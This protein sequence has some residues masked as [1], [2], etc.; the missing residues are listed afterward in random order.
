VSVS[1]GR[2]MAIKSATC[3]VT[4]LLVCRPLAGWGFVSKVQ[5][6]KPRRLLPTEAA[7]AVAATTAAATDDVIKDVGDQALS[8]VQ[9]IG[10]LVSRSANNA[11]GRDFTSEKDNAN[12]DGTG[13]SV[14]SNLASTID[15]D[16]N[17]ER[18]VWAALANLEKDSKLATGRALTVD[19]NVS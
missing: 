15:A 9:W 5:T 14:Y 6:Q 10:S 11:D 4:L 1:F 12:I 18:Q 19:G 16:E 7:T 8:S 13:G 2:A 3:F 17:K